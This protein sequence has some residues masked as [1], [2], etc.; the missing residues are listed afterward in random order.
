M[1]PHFSQGSNV[2]DNKAGSSLEVPIR[3]RNFG[4]LTSFE[5]RFGIRTDNGQFVGLFRTKAVA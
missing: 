4:I 3:I 2:Y 1:L 5:Y